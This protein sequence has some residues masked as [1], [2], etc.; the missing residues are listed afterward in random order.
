MAGSWCA[1]ALAL[2]ARPLQQV[3]VVSEAGREGRPQFGGER[4]IVAGS[5]GKGLV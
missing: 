2:A 1:A 5:S 3:D 4:G